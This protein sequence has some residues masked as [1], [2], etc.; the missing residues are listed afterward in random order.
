MHGQVILKNIFSVLNILLI[1]YLMLGER[2]SRRYNAVRSRY[3]LIIC[4]VSLVLFRMMANGAEPH[5]VYNYVSIIIIVMIIGHFLFQYSIKYCLLLGSVFLSVILLG[6]LI[7]CIFFY[8]YSSDGILADLSEK[9]QIHMIL[10]AEIVIIIGNLVIK[11][12]VNKIP[13]LL[14]GLNVVT[15]IIPLFINI[16][17]MAI[18]ADQLY[19]DKRMIVDNVWSIITIIVVCIVVFMGTV[20][21]IVV[22]ENYL[23][24]KKIENEKNLQISE[25]SL[26][27]DYYMKQSNDMENI[28]KISH[29]IKNHLEALRGNVDYQQKQEYIDGIESKLDIYQS[30]YK[31][32]NAFLD[33]LLHA[34]RLEALEKKIEFKVFADFTPF[35]RVKNEDLCV[36]VSNTVDNALRECQLMKEEDP[37]VECLIQLKA[38]KLKGFL[39]IICENTLRECQAELIKNNTTLE[40]SKEDKKNHGFGVKNIKSVVKD[41]GGEVSFHVVDG[42]F[43][44]SVI[45]PIEV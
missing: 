1:L 11:K 31:T 29:D 19:N 32:G 9:Y 23:N 21:N 18:C 37:E 30:Y 41:Y 25:M 20:C 24:V 14:S 13:L 33:N 7:S 3:S 8:S 17:V 27:Y 40:T 38:R 39:S 5:I 42:M 6:Q 45:I 16:V 4:V 35:K 22:L 10:I 15:I 12:I 2:K 28:R 43:S 36:I 44:I 34:K 26:Q